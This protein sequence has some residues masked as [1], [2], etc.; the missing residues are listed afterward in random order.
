MFDQ[1]LKEGRNQAVLQAALQAEQAI[2]RQKLIA[3][4]MRRQ[5]FQAR[6]KNIHRLGVIDPVLAAHLRALHGTNCFSDPDFVKKL[7]RDNPMIRCPQ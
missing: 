5:G 6:G 3:E 1:L 7:L 4:D 2:R